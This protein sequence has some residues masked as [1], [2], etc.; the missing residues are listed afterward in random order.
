M[1]F[2]ILLLNC[3]DVRKN[4]FK[5]FSYDKTKLCQI[6]Q[7]DS[8]TSHSQTNEVDNRNMPT[9]IVCRRCNNGKWREWLYNRREKK[10]W[11]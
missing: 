5:G 11:C 1:I 3:L 4:V 8:E 7:S 10:S 2:F 9:P 6:N